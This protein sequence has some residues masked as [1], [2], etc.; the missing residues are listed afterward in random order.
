ME[1]ERAAH[2]ATLL[3]DG[4]VLVTGGIRSGEAALASAEL[5]DP[6]T[7]TFSPTGQMTGVRSGHTATLLKNGL[8]LIAGGFDD[9][10]PVADR[11]AIRRGDRPLRVDRL[12]DRS[13]GGATATLLRDGRVLVAGGYDGDRSLASADLYDPTTG[14]FTRTGSMRAPRAAH[15]ATRLRDGRV[16]VTGGGN[17][18]DSVL[19]SAEIYEPEHRPLLH[20][21]LA[22]DPPPQ[23]RRR[24]APR[25]T[26]AGSRRLGRA[27]LGQPLP[28][29]RAVRSADWTVHA[30]RS[31]CR[32]RG[33]RCPTQSSSLRRAPCSSP[34]AHRS[35]IA[36]VA[37]GSCQWRGS[38]PP[39]TTRRR[40]C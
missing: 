26:G 30:H 6:Q 3:A 16:L 12:A 11:R 2:T 4:R 8:V 25:R 5:Y 40:R 27:G 39:V 1:V 9:E 32:R 29:R 24:A 35:S 28:Q 7:R 34:A 17:L 15:T 23:A 19:R 22:H 14:R 37:A 38:T 10:D 33:S 20:D 36:S 13:R 31:A 21:G 18:Q